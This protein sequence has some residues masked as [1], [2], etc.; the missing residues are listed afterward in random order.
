MHLNNVQLH[1]IIE[2]NSRGY[3]RM[4]SI[5]KLLSLT[6]NC[7]TKLDQKSITKLFLGHW[8]QCRGP[9]L[10]YFYFSASSHRSLLRTPG[11]SALLMH[12]QWYHAGH[13]LT[14]QPSL[15]IPHSPDH[16]NHIFSKGVWYRNTLTLIFIVRSSWAVAVAWFQAVVGSHYVAKPEVRKR[17][18]SWWVFLGL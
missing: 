14:L 6:L 12:Y 10:D 7:R 18:S 13:H 8:Q 16:D 4:L 3:L 11:D 2:E 1:N 9:G 15:C 17:K 5:V